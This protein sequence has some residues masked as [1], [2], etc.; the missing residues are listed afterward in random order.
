MSKSS[1]HIKP[2]KNNSESHNLRKTKLDYVK[3]EYSKYNYSV[4]YLA[5][6]DS[7]KELEI[8]AKELTGRSM[9]AKATPIREGVFLF[10]KNH[11]NEDLLKMTLGIEA[12]FGIKPIQLHVHRDEGHQDLETK[13]WKPNLHAHIIFE[14]LNRETGKSFKLDKQ[15]MSELQTYF[16]E[17]LKMERGKQSTRKHLNALEYKVE[18]QNENVS[19]RIKLLQDTGISLESMLFLLENDKNILKKARLVEEQLSKTK[20]N[21]K[22]RSL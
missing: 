7:R 15:K 3:E 6:S 12:K 16:A 9:Q 17:E 14:W 19:K 4:S 11:T 18:K 2:V 8:I 5:I 10:D 13:K 22:G 1:I 21:K 20:N